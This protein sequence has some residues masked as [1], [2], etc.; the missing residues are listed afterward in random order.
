MAQ[1][2][3]KGHTNAP[4]G[5][6]VWVEL[7]S[8]ETFVDRFVERTAGTRYRFERRGFIRAGR[9][10]RMTASAKIVRAKMR[11]TR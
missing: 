5:K 4:K 6:L 11:Q 1:R 10:V 8:G 9:V 7:D 3:L 2:R